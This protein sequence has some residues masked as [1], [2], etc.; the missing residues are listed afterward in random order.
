MTGI[1]CHFQSAKEEFKR[2]A[3]RLRELFYNPF[4]LPK[5]NLS[6]L[7]LNQNCKPCK[8]FQSAKEEFKLHL[9]ASL[10]LFSQS[11]QS[12]KEEFKLVLV[13]VI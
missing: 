7:A 1:D 11:F 10:S 12:A 9:K 2:L 8:S 6:S 4:S 13:S 5:R 3:S